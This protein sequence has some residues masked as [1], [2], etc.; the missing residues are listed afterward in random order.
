GIEGG[1]GFSEKAR[2][3]AESLERFW[4]VVCLEHLDEYIPAICTRIGAPA[5][6]FERRLETGKSVERRLGLTENL[7]DRLHRDNPM[8][9]QL[10]EKFRKAHNT[11]LI[12]V[13]QET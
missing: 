10:Y 8:D 11:Q 12:R 6:G 3:V 7:R 5:V 9:L 2:L 4:L 1:R 13:N